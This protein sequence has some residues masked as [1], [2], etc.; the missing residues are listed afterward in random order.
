MC[1]SEY[2]SSIQMSARDAL[3]HKPMYLVLKSESLRLGR[4]KYLRAELA[5]GENQSLD[6]YKVVQVKKFEEKKFRSARK[7]SYKFLSPYFV[8]KKVLRN[9]PI[10]RYKLASLFSFKEL[11]GTFSKAELRIV[12]LN[13]IEACKKL[14][15]QISSVIKRDKNYVYYEIANCDRTFIANVSLI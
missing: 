15:T 10:F 4:R 13:Y 11:S 6:E 2:L 3:Q 5:K 7:E 14:E 9:A 1:N 8:I 12:P